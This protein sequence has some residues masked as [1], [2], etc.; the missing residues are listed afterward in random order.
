VTSSTSCPAAGN[1]DMNPCCGQ[2]CGLHPPH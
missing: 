1:C 2:N